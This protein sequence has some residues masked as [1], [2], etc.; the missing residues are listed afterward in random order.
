MSQNLCV[1]IFVTISL[2]C[3]VQCFKIQSRIVDGKTSDEQSQFPFYALLFMKSGS[4]IF[5]CGGSLINSRFVLTAAHCLKDIDEVQVDLG[6]YKMAGEDESGRKSITVSGAQLHMHPDFDSETLGNDIGLI[7]LGENVIFSTVIQP[8]EISD[9][10]KIDQNIDYIAMGYGV[11]D[12][13]QLPEILQYTHMKPIS[14]TQCKGI[15]SIDNPNTFCAYGTNG[16]SICKGDSGGPFFDATKR[17]LYGIIDFQS[18]EGCQADPQ[19]FV[20]VVNYRSWI[21]KY[22]GMKFSECK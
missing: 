11:S 2:I 16:G 13:G 4:E 21:S 10:C 19:G 6:T 22:T 17:T 1:T 12:G 3:G 7:D 20:H 15:Y 9:Q 14:F 8:I 5:I 18:P